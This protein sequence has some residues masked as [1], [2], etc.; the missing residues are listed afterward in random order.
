MSNAK[1]LYGIN[2]E[3]GFWKSVFLGLQHVMLVFSGSVLM[4]VVICRSTG[5]SA[6]QTEYIIFA[7]III[8]AVSSFIQVRRFGKIGAGYLLFMGSSGA[9]WG[10][11]AT[12][13]NL[14]GWDL[15][16]VLSI[17][18]AP[19][20]LLL[21]YFYRHLRKIITPVVGGTVIIVIGISLLPIMMELW[22]G[23]PDAVDYFSWKRLLI[24]GITLAVTIAVALNRNRNLRLW[25][26]LIGIGMGVLLSIGLDYLD[27]SQIVNQDWIGLPEGD[28]PGFYMDFSPSTLSLLLIFM[29]ATFASTIESIGDCISVQKISDPDFKKVDYKSVQGCLYG[30]G[31]GNMMAGVLGTV[32]NTTYSGNIAAIELTGVAAKKVGY[33][34]AA[35]LVLMAFFPKVAYFIAY[36][37]D[38][39]LGGANLLF[40]STLL[41][42]GIRLINQHGLTYKTSL[43]TGFSL[44][45]GLLASI[46]LL[47]PAGVESGL[48]VLLNDGIAV[49]GLTA[50]GLNAIMLASQKRPRKIVLAKKQS[51]IEEIAPRIDSVKNKLGITESQVLK[52]NLSIEEIFAYMCENTQDEEGKVTIKV[53]NDEDSLK[54]DITD[55]EKIEDLDLH[56]RADQVLE[57]QPEKLGLLLVKKLTSRFE[58][59]EISGHNY[60][61]IEINE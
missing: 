45:M 1:L 37:P 34:G 39:V 38:P 8:T 43:I 7:T 60:I 36:I 14:H 23:K 51:L 24:G 9:Y 47:Y 4:P 31:V 11:V 29:V 59:L 19:I 18:S 42:V 30:D 2:D 44:A 26:I 12:A 58:H 56:D 27:T 48:S 57:D 5:T 16:A 35:I 15:V 55:S 10:A 54:V 17:L 41:S 22:V 20:E 46:G 49:S 6:E 13:V 50:I 21:S 40:L 61:S 28:W 53:L 3:P 52:L 32:P 33:Y 25:S